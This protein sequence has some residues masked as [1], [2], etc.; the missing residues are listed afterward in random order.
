M[1]TTHIERGTLRSRVFLGLCATLL[2]AGTGAYIGEFIPQ[3]LY[4]PI[5]LAMIIMVIVASFVRRRAVGWPFVI[6]FT[7]LSGM[8]LTPILMMYSQMLG[9]HMVEE[10]LLVT[11]GAFGVTAF[12]GSRKSADFSFLGSF[13]W[14]GL[15]VLIGMGIVSMIFPFS[16]ALSLGYTYL[17]IA[18]FVGYMLY[19]VNRLT[20]FGA[21]PQQVPGIVLS[22]YLDFVN[23]FLFILQL[24]GL[25]ARSRN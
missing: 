5:W 7:L 8:T 12:I 23:L 4:L 22:L 14:V 20:K 13:L 1:I 15:L 18:L 9:V 6:I 10:A 11:A 21:S 16:N 25:N 17:G 3:V 2:S 19:D 24:F